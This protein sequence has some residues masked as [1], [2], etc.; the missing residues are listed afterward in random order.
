MF[1]Q[2][3]E[4]LFMLIMPLLFVRW[5][6]KWMLLVG[7][8]AWLAR[9]GLFSLAADEGVVW[10]I[11]LG[12]VLHGICYD[13]F[14]VTG[15]IYVDK[16]A[17]VAIRGQAQGFLVLVTQGIGLG[18]GAQLIQRIVN[19]YKVENAESLMAEAQ[20]LRDQYDSLMQ[21]ARETPAEADA[22][23]AQA[24]TA[25]DQA[26]TLLLQSH[27]WEQIWLICAIAAGVVMVLFAALFHDRFSRSERAGMSEGEV[28]AAAAREEQP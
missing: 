13:F 8:F 27:D 6:V 12:I 3:A 23:T 19:S 28:S 17:P 5:G 4:I 10:M 22:L 11:L 18:I 16:K 21:Q 2:I 14:F 20:A 24:D 25:W 26:S 7:M 9:Y 1:G 15:Q